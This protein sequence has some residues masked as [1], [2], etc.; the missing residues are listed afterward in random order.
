VERV[1]WDD[2]AIVLAS[3]ICWS[4]GR[5]KPPNLYQ[6]TMAPLCAGMRMRTLKG[7]WNLVQALPLV[8]VHQVLCKYFTSAVH[9]CRSI[10]L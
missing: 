3:W 9:T 1:R 6:I 4:P 5:G 2:I 7:E 10:R 8:I